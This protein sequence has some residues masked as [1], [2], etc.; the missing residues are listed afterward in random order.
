MAHRVSY[1]FVRSKYV[2]LVSAIVNDKVPVNS[3]MPESILTGSNYPKR[4]PKVV[5]ESM[6][7]QPMAWIEV[8]GFPSLGFP[9]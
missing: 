7:Q 9:C 5:S 6:S 3:G 8:Y 4:N 1:C 2:N